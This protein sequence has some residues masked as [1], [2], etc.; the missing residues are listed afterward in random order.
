MHTA[1]VS[2]SFRYNSVVYCD[3]KIKLKY[4]WQ[5]TERN[6]WKL[7]NLLRYDSVTAD[8][9]VGLGQHPL[10]GAEDDRVGAEVIVL[11][12]KGFAS[13]HH[14][15][16][17]QMMNAPISRQWIFLETFIS[18]DANEFNVNKRWKVHG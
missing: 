18:L 4:G 17:C 3:N 11:R 12:C 16:N 1:A 2:V 8:R 10:L 5:L 15:V 6:E 13:V 7:L 9:L 14:V